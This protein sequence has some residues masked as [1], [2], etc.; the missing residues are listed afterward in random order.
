[1]SQSLVT[2]ENCISQILEE[3]RRDGVAFGVSLDEDATQEVHDFAIQNQCM[4]PGYSYPFLIDDLGKKG[5]LPT[6]HIPVRAL[7]KN[8]LDCFIV[9]EISNDQILLTLAQNYLG[10]FPK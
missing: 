2:V 8:P 9:R 5:E 7:V 6:G 1:M 3:V 10:Y 4:E